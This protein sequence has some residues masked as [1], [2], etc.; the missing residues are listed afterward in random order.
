MGSSGANDVI[1]ALQIESARGVGQQ[2]RVADD[3]GNADALNFFFGN[4]LEDY[5]RTNP[6]RVA[7]GDGDARQ[8]TGED[9][10]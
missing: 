1:T 5:F 4:C 2:L 10:H 9:V 6:G 3:D 8:R 7:H